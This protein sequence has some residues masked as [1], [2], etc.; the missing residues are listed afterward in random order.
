VVLSFHLCAVFRAER[1]KTAHEKI[2]KYHAMLLPA[3][4]VAL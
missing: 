4:T 1:G 3:K 2:G